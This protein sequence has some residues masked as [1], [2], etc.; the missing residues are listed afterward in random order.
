M[1]HFWF[2]SWEHNDA[3]YCSS[4]VALRLESVRLR[5]C[6]KTH[7]IVCIHLRTVWLDI[8]RSYKVVREYAYAV[9]VH[10]LCNGGPRPLNYEVLVQHLLRFTVLLLRLPATLL[11]FCL[12]PSWCICM[13]LKYC[14]LEEMTH[15]N[16]SVNHC[17]RVSL[18]LSI[19][20]ST[21]FPS[22]CHR[23]LLLQLFCR[24][25]LFSYFIS[26]F[27]H[28]HIDIVRSVTF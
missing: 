22:F 9:F 11:W 3:I 24:L 17:F 15:W 5:S 7:R 16:Q 27:C 26:L 14:L 18:S 21:S 12:Q 6:H 2:S 13:I 28:R 20:Y 23:P 1:C 8:L 19:L 25:I 4:C 10:L